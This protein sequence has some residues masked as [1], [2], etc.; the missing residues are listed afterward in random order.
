MNNTNHA[1]I[2]IENENRQNGLHLSCIKNSYDITECLIRNGCNYLKQDKYKMFPFD[3]A[4]Q[5]GNEEIVKLMLNLPDA[6]LF[7]S[8][9]PFEYSIENGHSGVTDIL[10]KN[11]NWKNMM[12]ANENSSIR[13]LIQKM[14]VLFSENFIRGIKK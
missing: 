7:I 13:M 1:Y 2:D 5:N 4:C 12:V 14:V 8:N 6:H 3:Y 11:K 10:L 9:K